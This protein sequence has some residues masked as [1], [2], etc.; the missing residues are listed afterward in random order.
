MSKYPIVIYT[1]L[2][3]FKSFFI[4]LPKQTYGFICIDAETTKNIPI[5]LRIKEISKNLYVFI[6]EIPMRIT[7]ISSGKGE[8]IIAAPRTG[9]V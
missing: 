5:P 1:K 3:I 8:A 6:L 4:K 9:N 7:P 2:Y